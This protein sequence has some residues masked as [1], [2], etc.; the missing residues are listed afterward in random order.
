M[1]AFITSRG[2]G[3]GNTAGYLA[4]RGLG[5]S[6]IEVIIPPPTGGGGSLPGQSFN[7]APD[8][9]N[10]VDPLMAAQILQEDEELLIMI[11]AFAETIRWH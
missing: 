4:S 3:R 2:L 11:K 6:F 8:T 10:K 5:Q 1:P 9:R 7:Q